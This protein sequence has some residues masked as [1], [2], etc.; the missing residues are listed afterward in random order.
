[1]L[2][3]ILVCLLVS[4]LTYC[5]PEKYVSGIKR[6]TWSGAHQFP[7]GVGVHGSVQVNQ[8]NLGAWNAGVIIPVGKRV[9]KQ[10]ETFLNK[11]TY[12]TKIKAH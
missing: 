1:M 11:V 5:I 8:G 7:N 3:S 10:T 2:K 9:N 12:L 6:Q 4:H